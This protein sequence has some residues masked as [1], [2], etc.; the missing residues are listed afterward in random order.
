[1]AHGVVLLHY[2]AKS[3]QLKYCTTALPDF[4]QS[5]LA[6]FNVSTRHSYARRFTSP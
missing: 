6:F 5:L 3:H 4:N 2:L 1:M